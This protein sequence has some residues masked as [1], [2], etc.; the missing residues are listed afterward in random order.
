[1]PKTIDPATTDPKWSI[2]TLRE[3]RYSQSLER[4]LAILGVFT[5]KKPILG[6]ADIAEELQMS[7]STTHR[8]VITLV[9]LGFLVQ[10][11]S[12][13]YRL[14]LSCTDLGMNSLNGTPMREHAEPHM[15][16]LRQRVNFPVSL[17][18]LVKQEVVL[19]DRM[20]PRR[21][22]RETMG[23][24]LQRGS[25][26]PSHCT[27]LGKVLLSALPDVQLAEL[28][29]EMNLEKRGPSTIRSKKK[30]LEELEGVR[31]ARFAVN[32]QELQADHISIAV[33][34]YDVEGEVTAAMSVSAHAE[35]ISLSDMIDSLEPQLTATAGSVSRRLGHR[36]EGELAA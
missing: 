35:E 13:K 32:D 19:M 16:E 14:G 11:A 25:H 8:Y 6:I 27:S 15:L 7:R 24:E 10:G 22:T 36:R 33:P 3:P 30:L 4:G 9:E 1:M 23:L 17:G 34:V 31:E 28:I 21:R 5:A 20:K 26:L 29:H 2:P 12:R 18:V